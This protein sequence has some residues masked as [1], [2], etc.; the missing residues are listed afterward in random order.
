M[1]I[2]DIDTGKIEKDL[3][4]MANE[5][6]NIISS[7]KSYANRV[8]MPNGEYNW[9]NVASQIEDCATKGSKYLNWL[10][11]ITASYNKCISD[12][13]DELTSLEIIDIVKNS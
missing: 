6:S 7:A 5:N 10:S 11:S 1:P 13:C 12:K 9:S 3:L 4:P 8:N 2:I